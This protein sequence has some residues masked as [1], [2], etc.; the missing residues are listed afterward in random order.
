M[1]YAALIITYYPDQEAFENILKIYKQ[2][3]HIIIIDNS[4][5]KVN[6]PEHLR[7]ITILQNSNIGGIAGGINRGIEFALKNIPDLKGIFIFDQDSSVP[8]KYIQKMIDF[9]ESLNT[10]DIL[11]YAPN[12]FDVN[13]KTFGSFYKFKRFSLKKLKCNKNIIYPTLTITSGMLL[14]IKA[15]EKVGFFNEDYLVDQVDNEYCIR[16]WKAGFKIAVNC[17]TVLNHSIGK[18]ENRKLLFLTVKPNH[19]NFFRKYLVARN[20]LIT[21]KKYPY[22]PVFIW[23]TKVLTHEILSVLFFEKEKL[24]KIRAIFKGFKDGLLY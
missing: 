3:Q 9:K 12:F 18:R 11:I 24:K 16:I 7:G 4:E 2:L 8:D 13:S 20:S 10:Q 14:D 15:I 21:L 6:F 22:I 19:H 1:N 23:E 17:D 5:K